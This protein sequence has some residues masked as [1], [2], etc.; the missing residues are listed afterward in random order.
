MKR[1]EFITLLGGAGVIWPLSARAQTA[2]KMRRIGVL[3]NV[4]AEDPGGQSEL[5]AFQRALEQLGWSESRN[6]QLDIRWGENDVDRDRQ[7]ATEL[8]G[9]APDVILASRTLSVAALQRQ[10]QTIPIVFDGVS[11]PV[12]AGFVDNLAR[13]GGN[14]TGFMIFEY[15]M[16]ADRARRDESGRSSRCG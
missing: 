3:M 12:G 15:S 8:I 11:D 10:T 1:R 2:E 7:Y 9:L 4:A 16:K 14:V 13:P 6:V 5:A